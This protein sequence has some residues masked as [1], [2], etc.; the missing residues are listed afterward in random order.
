[1]TNSATIKTGKPK[2]A[3]CFLFLHSLSHKGING[4]SLKVLR[5]IKEIKL[6][7]KKQRSLS[8]NL[9]CGVTESLPLHAPKQRSAPLKDNAADKH[10]APH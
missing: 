8:Q 9:S 6:K 7:A 10:L 1:M 2:T 3:N 5:S 4:S